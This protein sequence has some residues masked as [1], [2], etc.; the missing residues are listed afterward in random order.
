[1]AAVYFSCSRRLRAVHRRRYTKPTDTRRAMSSYSS[2]N[3]FPLAKLYIRARFFNFLRTVTM[4]M[5]IH[6]LWSSLPRNRVNN[7]I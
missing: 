3:A 4:M 1:M 2:S 7:A 5:I 6:C